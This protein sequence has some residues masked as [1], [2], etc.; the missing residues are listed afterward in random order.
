MNFI[1]YILLRV[2]DIYSF[3]LIAYALLSWVPNL[4]HSGLG[5]LLSRLVQPILQPFRKLNLQ[6][7]GLDFTVWV[8][9]LAL[10]LFARFLI[11]VLYLF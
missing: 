3:I 10:N 1:V 11:Q 5:R 8:A 6:F 7:G 9:M 2:V 4:Y